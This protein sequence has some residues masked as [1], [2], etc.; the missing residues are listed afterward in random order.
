[1][2][3]D[4]RTTSYATSDNSI[5]TL[6][7]LILVGAVGSGLDDDQMEV[8]LTIRLWANLPAVSLNP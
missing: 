7:L 4:G 1:M 5:F 3:P 2:N 8:F 6:F